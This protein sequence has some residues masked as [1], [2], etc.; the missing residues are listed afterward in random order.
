[1]ELCVF[2]TVTFDAIYRSWTATRL[3]DWESMQAEGQE[4]GI[5]QNFLFLSS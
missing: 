1:M 5:Q 2:K 3:A 4:I